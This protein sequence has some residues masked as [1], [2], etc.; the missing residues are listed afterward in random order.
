MALPLPVDNF[1]HV[2]W[3]LPSE[4]CKK[5]EKDKQGNWIQDID[6]RLEEYGFVANPRT[7][8]DGEYSMIFYEYGKFPVFKHGKKENEANG[9]IPQVRLIL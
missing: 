9:G 2:I 8:F 3:Q 1:Y 7:R 6:F 5:F 4:I